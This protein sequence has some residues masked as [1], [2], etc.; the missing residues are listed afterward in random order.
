MIDTENTTV[1]CS[2]IG[3]HCNTCGDMFDPRHPSWVKVHEPH[4]SGGKMLVTITSPPELVGGPD[5]W[6][7]FRGTA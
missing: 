7:E 2:I 3:V 1:E 4:W 5:L 6:M